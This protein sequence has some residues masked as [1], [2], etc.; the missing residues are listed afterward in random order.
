VRGQRTVTPKISSNPFPQEPRRSRKRSFIPNQCFYSTSSID[1]PAKI[2]HVNDIP[3]SEL[4]GVDRQLSN[5]SLCS[6]S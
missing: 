1:F 2:E 4:R 6:H 3:F 5:L